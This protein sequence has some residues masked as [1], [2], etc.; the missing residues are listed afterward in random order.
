MERWTFLIIA[1]EDGSPSQIRMILRDGADE[2]AW[3]AVQVKVDGTEVPVDDAAK[4]Y[5]APEWKAVEI[6][7]QGGGS[8][9]RWEE[10]KESLRA[11]AAS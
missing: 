6:F 3:P 7:E 9:A 2:S 10:L 11:R 5:E 8:K 1:A 4:D